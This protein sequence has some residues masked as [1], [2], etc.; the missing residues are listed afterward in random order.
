MKTK[1]IIKTTTTTT[2]ITII[3]CLFLF[4]NDFSASFESFLDLDPIY[5][6]QISSLMEWYMT[7]KD[8]NIL[9]YGE[10][11]RNCRNRKEAS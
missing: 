1:E 4:I 7:R 9:Y 2:A 10:K 8:K 6:L 5:G 11:K 3:I